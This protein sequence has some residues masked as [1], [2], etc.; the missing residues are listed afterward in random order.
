[1]ENEPA[2]KMIGDSGLTVGRAR[3]W[4]TCCP[5]RPLVGRHWRE[6]TSLGNRAFPLAPV[7]WMRGRLHQE[8]PLDQGRVDSG[9]PEICARTDCKIVGIKEW[10]KSNYVNTHNEIRF[11]PWIFCGAWWDFTDVNG[12]KMSDKQVWFTVGC[13]RET[14]N[15]YKQ[16][17]KQSN[18]CYCC[19][20]TELYCKKVLFLEPPSIPPFKEGVL[21]FWFFEKVLTES[22]RQSAPHQRLLSAVASSTVHK[23]SKL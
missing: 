14:N 23:H 6:Q 10:A 11:L 21:P 13:W 5:R 18:C 3:K 7:A 12:V 22:K 20:G 4:S 1:M 9:F 17:N 8:K 19:T 16:T 15:F 2:P